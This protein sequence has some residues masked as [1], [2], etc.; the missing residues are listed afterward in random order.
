MTKK[1]VLSVV[2]G[3]V[4]GLS[5]GA[6]LIAQATDIV[7]LTFKNGDVISADVWNAIFKRINDTRRLPTPGALIGEWSCKEA[8]LGSVA[9]GGYTSDSAGF[10]A[11]RVNTLTFGPAVNGV[12]PITATWIPFDPFDPR[13]LSGNAVIAQGTRVLAFGEATWQLAANISY[14]TKDTL[15]INSGTAAASLACVRVGMV[16]EPV[17]ALSGSVV[18]GNVV[19]TWVDQSSNETGFRV[20]ARPLAGSN[21]SNRGDFPPDS[22]GASIPTTGPGT[23]VVRVFAFNAAGP[24]ISSSEIQVVVP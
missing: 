10:T 1:H 4:I 8:R 16:P 19:L 9:D 13:P 6:G 7:P 17:D 24:S 2:A 15:E 12:M 21:W 5:I 18:G 22:T 11:T 14:M 3:A 23:F 20:Q